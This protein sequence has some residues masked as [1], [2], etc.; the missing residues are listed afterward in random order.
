MSPE[1][2]FVLSGVVAVRAVVAGVAV[3][4]LIAAVVVIARGQVPFSASTALGTAVLLA[5]GAASRRFGI[6]LPGN[7]FSSYVLGI[8]VIALLAHGWS[9]AVLVAPIGMLI[10]DLGLRRIPVNAALLNAAHLSAGTALVGLAYGALGGGTGMAALTVANLL[11]LVAVLALLPLVV[12]G[13]FYLELAA[14]QSVAWVDSRLTARWETIVYVVSTLLALGW[15]AAIAPDLPAGAVITLVVLLAGATVGS[16]SVIRLGVHAD[17]LD[18]VQRLTGAIA[19]DIS[20]SKSFGRIQDLTRRLVPWEQMGFTR[21]DERR[22]EMELI[23]DTA[24]A[25]GGMKAN[26]RY[27]ADAGLTGDA[28]RRGHAVVAHDLRPDQVVLAG[29]ETPGAE[30]LLPLHH[31]G[32]LVGLWSIRHSNPRMY[33]DS[34]GELLSLLAPQVALMLALDGSVAPVATASD[35]MMQYV[36]TLTATA[37]EIHASS[38]EVAASAQRASK[39]AADAATLVAAAAEGADELRRGASD[40]AAAGEATRTAGTQMQQNTERVRTATQGAV[41]RLTDLA[42]TADESAGEVRRLRDVAGQVEK[43]SETIGF[44]ANQT[45]LLALNATIEAARAGQHGRGFAVVADEVHKLAEA[46]AREARNVSKAVQET[47]RALDRAAQLLERIR[48]DL[49]DVVQ[50]SSGWVQDLDRISEAA[51]G[52]ARAGQRVGEVARANAE[53][54]GRVVDGLREGRAGAQTST[55]ETEAV[56]AAAAEQLRAIEDLA[57]GATQLSSLAENLSRA[58]R[59][60]RGENA[61]A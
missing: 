47:R 17:E 40:V 26:F 8:V 56:A 19:A 48:A 31:G 25:K 13:T 16:V 55:Q 42:T 21:F 28:I 3:A 27:D 6:A 51:A 22:R 60:V 61:R 54:A 29:D 57:Q 58:V 15:F 53:T 49:G 30:I 59:F 12:N 32:R 43:F 9:Y 35:K 20:L 45:N 1:R 41:R 52:T 39:G 18:L 4:A 50:S 44:V 14:S 37:Q 23:V 7:G 10:G 34:D 38:Q 2:G 36:E 24:M 5:A 46:S 33:R 11:P